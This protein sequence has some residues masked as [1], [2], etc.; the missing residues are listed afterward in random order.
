MGILVL[1][2]ACRAIVELPREERAA[3]A[4]VLARAAIDGL[5][6]RPDWTALD[7]L[8]CTADRAAHCLSAGQAVA[9]G[10]QICL[11]VLDQDL[12]CPFGARGE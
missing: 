2:Q 4:R 3:A 5:S 6:E 1:E 7:P 8:E 10:N 11:S 12:A 9:V